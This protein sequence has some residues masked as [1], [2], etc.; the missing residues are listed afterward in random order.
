MVG[1]KLLK[2]QKAKRKRNNTQTYTFAIHTSH[3]TK[4]KL[5]KSMS[6]R[7]T[8]KKYDR[9]TRVWRNGGLSAKIQR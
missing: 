9:T 4:P 5:Q 6:S 1:E 2:N 7:G 8:Q 3:R